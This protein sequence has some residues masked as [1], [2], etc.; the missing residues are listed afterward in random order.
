[1]I[2][3][4]KDEQGHRRHFELTFCIQIGYVFSHAVDGT[5][6]RLKVLFW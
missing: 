5:G 2:V 3:R 4:S 1:V 6:N